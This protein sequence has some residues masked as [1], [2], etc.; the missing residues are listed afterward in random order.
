MTDI[1]KN[2]STSRAALYN[3]VIEGFEEH[4]DQLHAL[5]ASLLNQ[6]EPKDPKNPEDECNLAAWRLAQIMYEMLSSTSLATSSRAILLD[7][8]NH[9]S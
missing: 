2:Q 8:L 3:H 5:A 7:G 1:T 9:A 6:V 4:H